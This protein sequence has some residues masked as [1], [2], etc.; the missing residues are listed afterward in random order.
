MEARWGWEERRSHVAGT[1]P[2]GDE[3]AR[4]HK[5]GFGGKGRGRREGWER[6]RT[7][8]D[9]EKDRRGGDGTRETFLDGHRIRSVPSRRRNPPV[10]AISTR[11]EREDVVAERDHVPMEV[12]L[13]RTDGS[14]RGWMDDARRGIP[15]SPSPSWIRLS[16][17]TNGTEER[18]TAH[19]FRHVFQQVWQTTNHAMKRR[20]RTSIQR[21]SSLLQNERMVCPSRHPWSAKGR[22]ITIRSCHHMNE[23]GARVR[24]TAVQ[25]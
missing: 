1:C 10:L 4:R 19:G 25:N 22:F 16:D 17:H 9:E 15:F 21:K 18:S 24:D 20:F 12:G 3:G 14:S 7:K 8:I 6:H 13:E 23:T 11:F 2:R 5:V